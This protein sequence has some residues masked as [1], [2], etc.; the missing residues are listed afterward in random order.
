MSTFA[1]RIANFTF[2][3]NT[4]VYTLNSGVIDSDQQLT[5]NHFACPLLYVLGI[6]FVLHIRPNWFFQELKDKKNEKEEVT[7][8]QEA[9][10]VFDIQKKVNVTK[11]AFM[12]CKENKM[13][14]VKLSSIEELQKNQCY[15]DFIEPRMRKYKRIFFFTYDDIDNQ[16][17][18][19]ASN[20]PQNLSEKYYN[21]IM[22]VD[23]RDLYM[24]ATGKTRSIPKALFSKKFKC[25]SPI[26]H[27]LV[28]RKKILRLLQEFKFIMRQVE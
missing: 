17:K 13:I 10:I 1:Q 15:I 25:F 19:L 24:E 20:T 9:Y 2:P 4:D 26:A 3:K 5:I 18:I 23:I 6:V 16:W 14:Q 7:E 12:D 27:V 11:V 21:K 22:F 28:Y 8:E